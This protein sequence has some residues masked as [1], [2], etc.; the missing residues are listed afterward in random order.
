MPDISPVGEREDMVVKVVGAERCIVYIMIW[1][2]AINMKE[3]N[4]L[5]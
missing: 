5:L 4:Y 2:W 1:R 3:R